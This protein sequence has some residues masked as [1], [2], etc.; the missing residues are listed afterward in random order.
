[1]KPR[2]AWTLYAA[3]TGGVGFHSSPGEGARA[4]MMGYYE[5]GHQDTRTQS[6]TKGF[7]KSKSLVSS[8]LGGEKPW[9]NNDF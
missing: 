8:C 5:N 2:G 1:M 9:R 4:V 3:Q 6:Y 7:I